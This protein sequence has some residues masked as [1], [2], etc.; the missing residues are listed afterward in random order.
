[1]FAEVH[2]RDGDHWIMET[3]RGRE[4]TLALNSVP[5]TISMSELYNGIPLPETADP[6]ISMR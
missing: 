3:P 1:M 6:S 2:R 5:V 4:A